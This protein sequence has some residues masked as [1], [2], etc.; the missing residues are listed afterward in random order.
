[1]FALMD[2]R[3]AEYK[4]TITGEAR[5]HLA[6]M[7]NHDMTAIMTELDKLVSY[8][9]ER[10]AIEKKDIDAIT[11][12]S[13]EYSIFRITDD[14]LHHDLGSAQR[15]VNSLLQNGETCFSLLAVLTYQYRNLAHIRLALDAGISL[16]RV[17]EELKIS[18][19]A[20]RQS[21]MTVRRIPSARLEKGYQDCLKTAAAI[22][23]GRSNERSSFDM[24]LIRLARL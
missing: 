3:L 7:M 14:L 5:E 13:L 22:R 1:M 11:T 21:E 12:P 10:K 6:V 20:A 2:A 24:L 16:D 8:I 9:G 18:Y 19:K 17:Q 23:T 15:I 4:K